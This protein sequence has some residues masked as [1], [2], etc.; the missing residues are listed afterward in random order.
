MYIEFYF[1]SLQCNTNKTLEIM[2]KNRK[3]TKSLPEAKKLLALKTNTDCVSNTG[4]SI[5]HLRSKKTPTRRFFVGTY[6][7]W[8]NL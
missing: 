3:F 4:T 2:T 5:F 7:E 8:L 1:V 6:Q